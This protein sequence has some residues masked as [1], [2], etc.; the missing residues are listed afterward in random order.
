MLPNSTKWTKLQLILKH[1]RILLIYGLFVNVLLSYIRYRTFQGF[2]CL[3][4]V[5][6]RR[7]DF[8]IDTLALRQHLHILNS[9]FTNPNIVKV[10]HGSDGGIYFSHS[11]L[12]I[13]IHSTEDILWLQRD[14]GIYVVNL[15]D[16]GQVRISNGECRT[17]LMSCS[18]ITRVR[19]P[20]F[21]LG[22]SVEVLL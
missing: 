9:S 4:Q 18:G 12:L 17:V 2:V 7:E 5:S 15:F 16:T 8:I 6:T 22:L 20:K 21:W 14:F 19:I 11:F 10:L 3:M 1:M 13:F